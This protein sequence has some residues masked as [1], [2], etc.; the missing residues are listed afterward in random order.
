MDTN[1]LKLFSLNDNLIRNEILNRSSVNNVR[2]V[3]T[4]IKNVCKYMKRNIQ[5]KM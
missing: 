5:S 1:I 3:F 2:P 4:Y